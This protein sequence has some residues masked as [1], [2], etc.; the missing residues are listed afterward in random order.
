MDFTAARSEKMLSLMATLVT[1]MNQN[2]Q[3]WRAEW[4]NEDDVV[5][6]TMQP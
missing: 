4:L 5:S 3:L 1:E 2:T 6:E